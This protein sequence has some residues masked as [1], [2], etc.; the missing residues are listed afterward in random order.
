MGLGGIAGFPF[1][2]PFEL[3]CK[4]RRRV[5]D[6]LLAVHD[7]AFLSLVWSG[8]NDAR[9]IPLTT[10][11]NRRSSSFAAIWH[12]AT[13]FPSMY[14]QE[15]PS[16]SPASRRAVIE[17]FWGDIRTTDARGNVS[18]NDAY[19]EYFE[20]QCRLVHQLA[21]PVYRVCTQGNIHEV[22]RQLKAGADRETIKADLHT[23]TKRPSE[24][25]DTSLNQIIELAVR[26][27]LMVHTGDVQRGVTGQTAL[28]WREGCLKD[29]VAAHFQHQ[30]ILTDMVKF[31]KL[32]HARNI[33]RIAGVTIRWTPNLVDT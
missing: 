33:E 14:D 6:L 16:L 21:H 3:S 26:L 25:N 13:P 23:K 15:T 10:S 28:F 4:A 30:R 20:T 9:Q 12:L 24:N 7:E 2:C 32:F 8:C 27:W 17:P 22:V 1:S 5:A 31:E 29:G 19:F 11:Q 18:E